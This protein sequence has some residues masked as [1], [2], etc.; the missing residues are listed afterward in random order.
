MKPRV[1]SA[2]GIGAGALVVWISSR[3][4]W[5]TI[6][7]FD[8]KS[9]STTQSIVGATWSTEIMALALALLAAFAAALV[10]RRTGRRII[11]AISALIAIGASLSPL[12]LL[13]QDPDAERARTLLTSGVA[14]QK[15][16][17]GTLLSDWAEITNITTHPLA[18]VV[19]MIGC[20]LALVGG[21]VLA[22]KPGENT[23]KGNQ[24]ERKEARAQ[25]I[26]TDLQEEPD[27]G[28]VMW[29]ALDSDIDFTE[30]PR[31]DGKTPGQG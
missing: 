22:M 31:S 16:N 20:A 5:V 1:L 18:A 17:S 10:L 11:G 19:A 7:A 9:G 8:D 23:A 24:Y 25:K 6:E 13:T 12:T 4:N 26:H 29:D 21:I 28:R 3:M 27:S 30:N 2:L 15:A 14:N